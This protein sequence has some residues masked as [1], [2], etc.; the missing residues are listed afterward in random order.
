MQGLALDIVEIGTLAGLFMSPGLL[1]AVPGGM[2]SQKVGERRF[3]IACL[4]A[5]TFGGLLCGFAEGC[6]TLWL[7]RLSSGFGAIG[8][9]VAMSKIVIDWFAGKEINTAMAVFLSGFPVGIALALIS[10]GHLATPD[11]WALAF[12]A[13]SAF[14]FLALLVFLATYRP[15]PS[16]GTQAGSAPRLNVTEVTLVSVVGL[17]WALWNGAFMISVSF[18]PLYLI[19]EGHSAGTAASLMGI[20]VWASIL[21]VPFGGVIADKIKRV[22]LL[23]A[24]TTLFWGFGMLLVIPLSH[25][26]FFLVTVLAATT[27]VGSLSAGAIVA[28]TSTVLRPEVRSAGMGVFYM[29]LYGG[30]ALGPILGGYASD[31]TGSPAAPIYL[32]AAIL[33]AS[34][35]TLWLFQMLRSRY[36]PLA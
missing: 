23:I 28:L 2:I 1:L 32:F 5:M 11:G 19:S 10:L 9:N 4:L 27:V 12:H 16:S 24:A 6:W 36:S 8:I 26:P 25:S 7:G 18:V 20:G 35:L 22:N 29:W 15:A 14:S 33:V 31:L 34:V 3:L 30:L 21:G 13:T 17:I